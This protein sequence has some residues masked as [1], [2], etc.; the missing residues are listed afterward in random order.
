MKTTRSS[1]FESNSSSTHSV[2]ISTKGASS[3]QPVRPLVT[4]GTLNPSALKDYS[5]S[6]GEASVIVCDTRDK[7]AAIVCHW[8]ENSED[9]S[10]ETKQ[11]ALELLK[12]LCDYT[13]I[14]T[15]KPYAYYSPYNEYDDNGDAAYAADLRDDDLESFERFVKDVVLDYDKEI[16]DATYPQ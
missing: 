16:T 4:E 12:T 3:K 7:K 1:V 9:V 5:V 8:L 6:L 10:E 15:I 13:A 2:T 11:A 14:L